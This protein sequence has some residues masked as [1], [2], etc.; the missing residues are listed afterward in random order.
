[1]SSQGKSE[2]AV[3]PG[4]AASLDTE[5]FSLVLGGPLYQLLRKARLHESVEAHVLRRVI[6]FST[7]LWLPLLL[8]CL[9]EGSAFGGVA[10]PF[11]GDIETHA[12]FLLAT[13]LLIVAELVVHLRTRAIV[14]QFLERGLLTGAAREAFGAALKSAMRLRNALLPELTLMVLVFPVGFYVRSQLLDVHSPTWFAQPED[15][16]STITLAGFW[17]YGVSNPV[18]QFLVFRWYFRLF[19]WTRFLWQVSRTELALM[20]THP[21]RKG[22]LG[23]LG[24]SAYALGPLIAAHG[25][26]ISGYV[27]NQIFYNGASLPD[28]KVEVAVLVVVL[29]VFVLGPLCI[30]IPQ[31]LAAKRKG[32]REYGNLAMEY[33]RSFDRRWLRSTGHDEVELLGAADI[34]SLADLGNAV[35]IISDM[36]PLPFGRDAFINLVGAAV[37]PFAPLLLTMFPL[38]VLLE[39]IVAALF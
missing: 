37:I 13:P 34:Q 38:E 7:L 11:I 27:A 15:G 8:L 10:V 26:A 19:I 28:F 24:A 1:M 35:G 6:A 22:G 9:V 18:F 17:F 23:F 4:S 20:P 16:R 21:D 12:R 39:R 30:F 29:M 32:L 31:L 33:A 5:D 14:A 25:V 3:Q 36:K 2:V